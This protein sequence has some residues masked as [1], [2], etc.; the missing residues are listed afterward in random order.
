MS[1]RKLAQVYLALTPYTAAVDVYS[2]A[3]TTW[4]SCERERK[5]KQ[6]E[7]REKRE[8]DRGRDK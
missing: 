2:A 5:E 1:K 8:A 3:M 6:T 4:W 7:G